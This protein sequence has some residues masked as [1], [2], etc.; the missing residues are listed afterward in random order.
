MR[1]QNRRTAAFPEKN[2]SAS[3]WFANNESGNALGRQSRISLDRFYYAVCKT[4]L[5]SE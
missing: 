2:R 5:Q 1:L 3:D 4:L